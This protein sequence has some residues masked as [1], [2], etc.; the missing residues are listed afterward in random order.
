VQYPLAA[1]K[2]AAAFGPDIVVLD[3]EAGEYDLFASVA[4]DVRLIE[5][6]RALSI[7]DAEIAATLAEA[8]LFGKQLSPPPRSLPKPPNRNVTLSPTH[9][10]AVADRLRMATAWSKMLA[11]Y[12]GRGFPRILATARCGGLLNQPVDRDRVVARARAFDHLAPYTPFQGDCFYRC[13]ML[14]QLLDAD[15]HAVDWVFGIRTWPFMAHCWLQIDDVC[16]TDHV[17][18]LAHF[19]PILAT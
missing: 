17:D 16:L 6:Q 1:T 11:R 19:S 5:A 7:E 14:L 18:K 4:K 15:A 9:S 13:F 2:Y 12:H 10:V 8:G 3:I